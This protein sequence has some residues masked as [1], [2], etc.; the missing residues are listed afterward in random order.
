MDAA[1]QED[2]ANLSKHLG[3]IAPAFTDE[4]EQV[5]HAAAGICY[6]LAQFREIALIHCHK[7]IEPV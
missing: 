1:M 5:R 6:L 7:R 2:S 4:N 3:S